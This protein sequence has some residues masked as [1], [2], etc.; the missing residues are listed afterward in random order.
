[1]MENKKESAQ[2]LS[3]SIDDSGKVVLDQPN[4]Q[5]HFSM[6]DFQK[7]ARFGNKIENLELMR[8]EFEIADQDEINEQLKPYGITIDDILYSEE[9]MNEI[10][11]VFHEDRKIDIREDQA[12]QNTLFVLETWPKDKI[13]CS[14]ITLVDHS[15][16]VSKTVYGETIKDFNEKCKKAILDLHKELNEPEICYLT[17]IDTKY[18]TILDVHCQSSD[19]PLIIDQKTKDINVH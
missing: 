4:L 3:L 12:L 11:E 15:I 1:M 17:L 2:E 9:L 10:E 18:E 7:I 5:I 16:E 19:V 13:Y 6:S 8:K 14:K